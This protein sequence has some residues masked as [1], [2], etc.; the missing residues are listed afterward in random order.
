MPTKTFI[1]QPDLGKLVLRLAVGLILFLHGLGKIE[2]GMAGTV[3]L[4][5]SNGFPGWLGYGTYVGEVLAP[6]LM[7]L[8]KFTR[9]AGL[10][11]AFNML[12]TVVVAHRDIAFQRNDFG[13]W[14]IELNVVLLLGGLAVAL[15]GAGKFSLSKGEG[16]WD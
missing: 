6:L 13:G 1:D 9:P 14:Q 7:M 3:D 2:S 11:V 10:L 4:A 12:M 8:G 5:A 16:K 15:L